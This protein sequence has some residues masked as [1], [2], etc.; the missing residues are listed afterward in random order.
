MEPKICSEIL[1]VKK[2][3]RLKQLQGQFRYFLVPFP[4]LR[5]VLK[6]QPKIF[7]EPSGSMETENML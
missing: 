5:M 2:I 6:N 7:L 3:P 4:Q 1:S